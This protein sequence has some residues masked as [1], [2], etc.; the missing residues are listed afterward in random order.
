MPEGKVP[1]T[2]RIVSAFKELPVVTN[3]CNVAHAELGADG[4]APLEAALVGL[5]LVVS[6]WYRMSKGED[7]HGN[8]W[9]RDIGYAK[10]GD[11][12][13]IALRR[14]W[15]NENYDHYGEEV[16]PF[17]DAPRWLCIESTAKLPDLFEELVKRT[18][19]TTEKLRSS[20][21]SGE[22]TRSRYCCGIARGGANSSCKAEGGQEVN[23]FIFGGVITFGIFA[24][25]LVC[26]LYCDRNIRASHESVIW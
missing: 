7:E 11:E 26:A 20:H 19:E 25:V 21:R 3:E 4:I 16:W 6:A 1:P 9:T 8:Y 12:W 13:R 14:T 23:S 2:E 22:G 10:I 18:K 5:N 15:G 17:K 24:I